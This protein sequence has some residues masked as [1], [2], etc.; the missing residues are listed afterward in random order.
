VFWLDDRYSIWSPGQMMATDVRF[1]D[2]AG[3][4][5]DM[6]T[7]SVSLYNDVPAGDENDGLVA[8]GAGAAWLH[9]GPY[10]NGRE[11]PFAAKADAAAA[12]L[13]TAMI[14]NGYT[15]RVLSSAW[16]GSSTNSYYALVGLHGDSTT[17]D[18]DVFFLRP[19]HRR[20]RP[21]LRPRSD[22]L[23]R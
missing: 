23:H 7:P 22:G 20:P 5:P 14:P 3:G 10:P 4:G 12:M 16:A 21:R 19:G 9:S 2:F 15:N 8:T 17:G 1:S 6:T 13:T 11:E 18:E